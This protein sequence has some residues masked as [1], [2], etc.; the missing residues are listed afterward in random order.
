MIIDKSP[1]KILDDVLSKALHS[2]VKIEFDVTPE[3]AKELIE[4]H[5]KLIEE[6]KDGMK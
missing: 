3:I 2:H 6:I 5:H 1:E 4:F